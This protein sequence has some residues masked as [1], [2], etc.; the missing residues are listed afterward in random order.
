MLTIIVEHRPQWE[1]KHRFRAQF[2]CNG[3][4]VPGEVAAATVQE[5]AR[6]LVRT[7]G[8]DRNVT[9]PEQVEVIYRG[10][11]E[12][13]PPPSDG[14]IPPYIWGGVEYDLNRARARV[15]ICRAKDGGWLVNLEGHDHAWVHEATPR[16]AV[17]T[18]LWV[19]RDTFNGA[20][21]LDDVVVM[22][23]EPLYDGGVRESL[24]EWFHV[25][26]NHKGSVFL[27]AGRDYG[28]GLI[29]ANGVMPVGFRP[30]HVVAREVAY[31]LYLDNRAE[32]GDRVDARVL[33]DLNNPGLSPPHGANLLTKIYE[34]PD[35][36]DVDA[37]LERHQ[38]TS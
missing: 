28:R 12:P 25:E 14:T 2:L 17:D 5:A 18:L 35:G 3:T 11:E 31:V 13:S 22:W 37:V 20:S 4:R 29:L 38:Q 1:R 27:R 26:W 19:W 9:S 16:Q 24:P 15:Y 7:H 30:R 34:E 6:D 32:I 8:A 23:G 21:F 10:P 33:W 36:F